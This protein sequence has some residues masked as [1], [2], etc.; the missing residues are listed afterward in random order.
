MKT[1][2]CLVKSRRNLVP[3]VVILSL[4]A[5]L[6]PG[7]PVLAA[8]QVTIS[9]ASGAVGTEIAITGTVFDSYKGDNIF[10]FFDD[11]EIEL[12]PFGVPQSGSFSVPFTIPIGTTPGRHW[13]RIKDAADA[14]FSLAENF[15]VVEETAIRLDTLDG[16]VGADVTITG[17][18]FYSG[19]SVNLYYYNVIAEKLGTAETS[20]TGRFSFHFVVPNSSGGFH[21]IVV[22][23]AE[24]NSAEIQFEVIPS[25][26]SNLDAAGPG[27]LLN[28]TG[29]GFGRRG[30]VDISIGSFIVAT[31]R[32]D[33]YGNFDIVFNIP[34]IK[35]NPYDITAKDDKGNSDKVKFTITA[36]AS[37]SLTAGAIGNRVIVEGSGFKAGETITIEYDRSPVAT[38]T[39][40]NNGAFVAAF[41]IPPSGAGDHI[42][43]VTDGTTTRNY[44]F[45]VESEAPPLPAM[46]LP[47]GGSGTKAQ[48]Y[49]DWQD[50]TDDSM[51]VVY[52]LQI[53]ADQNFSSIVIEKANLSESEYTLTEEE[54]LTTDF[55]DTPYFWR[56]KVK[57]SAGNESEW[58]APGSFI[59]SPPAVPVLLQPASG[60][61]VDYPV[62]FKW[63]A[64]SNL[65]PP[66]TY[67]LQVATDLD[68]VDLVLE[69]E[70]LTVP[71]YPVIEEDE[72]ILKRELTYYWR[73]KAID[74]VNNESNFSTP[75]SFYIIDTSF[76]FPGWA[77]AVL[78][79]IGVIIV[80]IIAFRV[81]RRTAYS[82]PE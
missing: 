4:A 52:S 56:L 27:D 13:V 73:V 33:D 47:A 76:S 42:I 11:Q 61:E 17:T 75:G 43:T 38:A 54:I 30:N 25:I 12:S 9:P 31:A 57:D 45:N 28:I 67:N 35:P 19:R 62:L 18:G 36:A 64:V 20:S 60:G 34:D 48:A 82:P 37:L 21:K 39:A 78:V 40:D 6:V 26:T 44:Y 53:A 58:S 24:G 71:E 81:G 23:N 10:I 1:V 80:V 5:M 29:T 32:T 77:T 70:G 74:S 7:I 72:L 50:V 15:F 46:L 49:L 79:I 69:Q 66:L 59:I 68:F 63:D 8:P 22:S 41:E 3:L 16:P 65:S 55:K 51:P 14:P 2:S